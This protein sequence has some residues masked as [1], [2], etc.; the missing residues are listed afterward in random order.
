MS[1]QR[2]ISVLFSD[3]VASTE[4]RSALGDV[5]ADEVFG[6]HHRGQCVA[7]TDRSGTVVKALGDGLMAIF[8]SA[9]DAV[10]AAAA[11]HEATASTAG[12]EQV[13]LAIRIGV[14]AGD[15]RMEGGDWFGTPVVEAARLCAA[16]SGGGVL[17]S[18]LVRRLAGTRTRHHFRPV[19]PLD[20]KGLTEPVL[21]HEVPIAAPPSHRPAQDDAQKRTRSATRFRI[22]GRF[23]VERDGTA[24][25][26][27]RFGS[28]KGRLLLKLLTAR[29]G[30]LVA[31]DDIIEVL[32]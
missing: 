13:E 17:V 1:G 29:R 9:A 26:E 8:D 5:R 16:A 25:D 23:S 30:R 19:G 7:V 18:D 3:V 32:W 2:T 14:S 22:V 20:L 15:A 24:V 10:D 12:Q 28:R 11:M 4:L 31:M 27:A 21:A 6:R